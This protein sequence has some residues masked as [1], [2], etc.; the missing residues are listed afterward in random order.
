MSSERYITAD[1]S[2]VRL[3]ALSQEERWLI[4]EGRR[5]FSES[6]ERSEFTRWWRRENRRLDP[7]EAS[8]ASR[9]CQDLDFRLG[10]IQGELPPIHYRTM[11]AGLYEERY[12]SLDRFCKVEGSGKDLVWVHALKKV[13][14]LPDHIDLVFCVRPILEQPDYDSAVEGILIPFSFPYLECKKLLWAGLDH[15]HDCEMLDFYHWA[16][17]DFDRLV[18]EDGPQDVS[19]SQWWNRFLRWERIL[20]Q[21][22]EDIRTKLRESIWKQAKRRGGSCKDPCRQAVIRGIVKMMRESDELTTWS[23]HAIWRHFQQ[24]SRRLPDGFSCGPRPDD[25]VEDSSKCRQLRITGRDGHSKTITYAAFRSYVA[26]AKRT[27]CEIG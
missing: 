22:W 17:K 25:G 6:P 9:V 27:V 5:R 19:I 18:N 7:G 26:E 3:E 16:E 12:G 1:G 11:V 15:A 4:D 24:R 23:A 2:T 14:I 8:P 21:S 20:D 13:S 10:I